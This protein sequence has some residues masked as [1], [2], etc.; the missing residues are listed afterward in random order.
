MT[1]GVTAD[2]RAR[3]PATGVLFVGLVLV[4]LAATALAWF[5]TRSNAREHDEKVVQVV[6][7]RLA[8]DLQQ[9]VSGLLG[10]DGFASDGI[11]EPAEFAAFATD[12]MPDSLYIALAYAEIVDGADRTRWEREVGREIAASDGAGGFVPAPSDDEY[13]VVRLVAPVNET[14][15]P[16]IGF[17][18][19]SD[20][21]RMASATAS[22]RDDRPAVV[23][24]IS[25]ANSAQPGLFVSEVVRDANGVTLGFVSGGIALDRLIGVDRELPGDAR[26]ALYLDGKRLSAVDVGGTEQ[27]FEVGGQTFTVRA[28]DGRSSN[29][30][31]PTLLGLATLGLAITAALARRADARL[32]L[33]QSEL[34]RRHRALADLGQRLAA[35][36]GVDQVIEISVEH[37]GPIVDAAATTLARL[38]PNDASRLIVRTDR[39]AD[40][41]AALAVEEF[42]P[43]SDALRA[44]GG[45]I[46]QNADDIFL[47][48]PE[49]A[50][51]LERAGV[52]SSLCV[53]LRLHGGTPFAAL[54]FCWSHPLDDV[55]AAEYTT[56]VTTIAELVGR[57]LERALVAELVQDRASQLSRLSQALAVAQDPGQVVAAVERWVP[58]LFEAHAAE[59]LPAATVQPDDDPDDALVRSIVLPSPKRAEQHVLRVR[60]NEP[61]ARAATVEAV[62]RTVGELI[63]SGLA[64]AERHQHE[65]DLIEELQH[66]LLLTPAEAADLDI[67][68]RYEPAMS[69]LGIG[70]DWYDVV[71]TGPDQTSLVVGDVTGHGP[72]A[73]AVMAELKAIVSHLLG[74]G[75]SLAEVCAGADSCL[76]R[77]GTYATMVVARIDTL[78]GTITS[79]NAGH[80]YPILRSDGSSR[81]LT[82]GRRPILG[83]P[84]EQRPFEP[85]EQPFEPGDLLLLYTDGLI[86]DRTTP[87]TESIDQLALHLETMEP[88]GA[89]ATIDLLLRERARDTPRNDD[90]VAILGAIRRP[91]PERRAGRSPLSD[92]WPLPF[93]R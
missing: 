83:L 29:V 73:V 6:A 53:A 45:V 87:I 15:T 18:I 2:R 12:V 82:G 70:G 10:V 13:F 17:D 9:T 78:A 41:V 71:R 64:R 30:V 22:E 5:D 36:G 65:H 79:V 89:A 51:D 3:P 1:T 27:T 62:L 75:A 40:D 42:H 57:A 37:G 14:T 68:V 90:D 67:A 85:D 72:P 25:L 20:P 31:L 76:L 66:S 55:L 44:V 92:R 84:T 74:A 46:L 28:D 50:A 38:D 88:S 93:A 24:P 69:L 26:V 58:R 43:L 39:T 49:H 21:L 34:L 33:R 32:Q 19:S 91:A 77:H 8:S 80:P 86:E 54:G 60:W 11:V 16:L 23:G 48:Y 47:R 4:G 56:V 61:I 35:A 7:T 59:L 52:E 63:G 81:Q